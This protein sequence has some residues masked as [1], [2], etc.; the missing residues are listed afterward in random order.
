MNDW[1]LFLLLW[2]LGA[3]AII[4]ISPDDNDPCA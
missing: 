3:I 4:A 1:Q 2:V